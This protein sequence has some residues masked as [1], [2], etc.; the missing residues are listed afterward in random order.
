M[1]SMQV[2]GAVMLALMPFFTGCASK[3]LQQD[4]LP[5]E[6]SSVAV[7]LAGGSPNCITKP[8]APK[9][10]QPLRVGSA[11]SVGFDDYLEP[12]TQPLPC[13]T[14]RAETRRTFFGFDLS[15]YATVVNAELTLVVERSLTRSGKVVSLEAPPVSHAN[16]LGVATASLKVD[17]S[18]AGQ[19][20]EDVAELPD[21]MDGDPFDTGTQPVVKVNVSTVVN[22][23]LKGLVPTRTFVLTGPRAE[24]TPKAYYKDNEAALSWYLVKRLR[25][26]YD[27]ATNPNAPQQ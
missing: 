8:V 15:K 9:S 2:V 11:E 19:L 26:T 24:P 20:L 27:A 17:G 14:F 12:G 6:S 5:S 4:L 22:R 3:I 18:N 10:I 1:S 25:V 13:D 16:K 21:A 23:M 7:I